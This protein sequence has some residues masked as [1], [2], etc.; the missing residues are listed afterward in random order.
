ML[1]SKPFNKKTLKKPGMVFAFFFSLVLVSINVGQIVSIIVP[2]INPNASP[3][4]DL[5]NDRRAKCGY[6]TEIMSLS[7]I[8]ASSVLSSLIALYVIRLYAYR[9]KYQDDHINELQMDGG[10][11][12]QGPPMAGGKFTQG[13]NGK[14][15]K[16][17]QQKKQKPENSQWEKSKNNRKDDY[18][19]FNQGGGF[20][21]NWATN[22]NDDNGWG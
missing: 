18:Q 4:R 9:A 14:G 1:H 6:A 16:D 8:A 17:K 7:L 10:K 19:S 21:S 2:M 20:G 5:E 15:G 22:D 13:G 12:N 3:D 11:S